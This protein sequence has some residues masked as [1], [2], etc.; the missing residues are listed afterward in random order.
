MVREIKQTK[1]SIHQ[2]NLAA[3]ILRNAISHNVEQTYIV[4]WNKSDLIIDIFI[5]NYLEVLLQSIHDCQLIEARIF[6]PVQEIRI[7]QRMNQWIVKHIQDN[8]NENGTPTEYFDAKK[9][10]SGKNVL[11]EENGKISL[12]QM[13]MKTPLGKNIAE[14]F[15]LTPSTELRTPLILLTRNYIEP[16]E[17]GQYA[18]K[19]TRMVEINKFT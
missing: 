11:T 8:D 2:I 17:I 16:N 12:L 1:R 6:N 19:L 13:G 4:Q 7:F 15:H 9:I 10:I 5:D 18:I 3:D 14:N